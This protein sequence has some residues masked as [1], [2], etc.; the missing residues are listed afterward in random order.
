[1]GNSS[2]IICYNC[3]RIQVKSQHCIAVAM[4]NQGRDDF[5]QP[6]ERS[7]AMRIASGSQQ[8][9]RPILGLTST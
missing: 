9:I 5:L 4:D 2:E 6:G 8:H 7:I 3:D 1:M